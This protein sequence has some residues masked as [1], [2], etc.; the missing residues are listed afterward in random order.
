MAAIYSSPLRR[1]LMTAQV[2]AGHLGLTVQTLPGLIDLDFGDWEG[3]SAKEASEQDSN[4]FNRW[5]ERPHEVR[6]PQGESLQD[7]RDRVTAAVEELALKHEGQTVALISHKAVC[8]VL[9]C[10]VLG[11]DD[12]HFWQVGQDV[13]AINVFAVS[14][15]KAMLSLLNDTCHLKHLD[16]HK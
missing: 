10:L 11:L 15:D 3:L 14:G 12:S 4:L 5:L 6:F 9:I 7:V 1:A 8:Q 16:L 2:A 13:A